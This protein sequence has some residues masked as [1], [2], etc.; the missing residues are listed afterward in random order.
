MNLQMILGVVFILIILGGGGLFIA[1]RGGNGPLAFIAGDPTTPTPTVTIAV[2]PTATFAPPT[3]I[4]PTTEM[5]IAVEPPTDTPGPTDTPEAAAVP[6]EIPTITPTPT[7]ASPILGG[8]DKVAFVHNDDIW[9]VNLDG[10][11]LKRLTVDGGEKSNLHWTP[12]GSA[13]AYIVGKCLKMV[14]WET[15]REEIIACFEVAEFLEGFEIS[16]D[17]KQVAISLNR[18]LWILPFDR[19]K[20]AAARFR[21]DLLAMG[22]CEILN[23]YT[24]NAVKSVH[25]GHDGVQ[26][27]FVF[28]GAVEGLRNDIIRLT[29]LTSCTFDPPRLDEFPG[30]RFEMKGYR[31]SPVIQNYGWDGQLLFAMN[32]FIRNGGF[33]DLYIYNGDTRKGELVNPINGVCCYRDT[34]WSPD[35]R[36]LTFA[37]QDIGLGANS[38]AEIYVIP[39]GTLGTGIDYVPIPLPDDF[40]TDPKEAPQP[41]LRPIEGP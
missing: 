22:D 16:P 12:D 28:L 15:E 34:R 38:V 7:T 10:S 9:I 30:E 23:P 35:G 31:N 26:M 36:Y 37:F 18:E 25:W 3:E 20:L 5:P 8:A 27:S 17:G 40:L 14:A 19:E 2:P 41:I 32:G 13:V 1:G 29:E 4:P 6:T 11:D 39:F 21:S 24:K 33:G